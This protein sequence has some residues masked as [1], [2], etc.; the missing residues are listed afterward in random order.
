[1]SRQEDT[2][3]KQIPSSNEDIAG[4]LETRSEGR[5]DKSRAKNAFY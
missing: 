5:S 4:R 3:A 2:Q 1:M